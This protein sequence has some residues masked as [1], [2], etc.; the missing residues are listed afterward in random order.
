MNRTTRRTLVSALMAA[1]G[2]VALVLTPRDNAP[3]GHLAAAGADMPVWFPVLVGAVF[4][5]GILLFL[6]GLRRRPRDRDE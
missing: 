2:L 5:L 6:V 1:L 4:L 3:R